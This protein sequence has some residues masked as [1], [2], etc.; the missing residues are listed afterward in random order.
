MPGITG[1][2]VST[3]KRHVLVS[4]F[5]LSS[6]L[7][8]IH[9]RSITISGRAGWLFVAFVHL[10]SLYARRRRRERRHVGDAVKARA[11]C[12]C[13]NS[14]AR[15]PLQNRHFPGFCV[16][17]FGWIV[18]RLRACGHTAGVELS[19]A[20]AVCPSVCY[21]HGPKTV[22]EAGG[23]M[24]TSTRCFTSDSFDRF[25]HKNHLKWH[26]FLEYDATTQW[27]S[28]VFFFFLLLCACSTSLHHTRQP[29]LPSLQCPFKIGRCWLQP[30]RETRPSFPPRTMEGQFTMVSA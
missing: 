28:E 19:I 18:R 3:Y 30:K 29:L 7:H 12:G 15:L 4:G 24:V 23:R 26:I 13:G 27:V 17:S 11:S 16:R 20:V 22:A 8:E 6:D 21:F 2:D 25:L 5:V 10:A 14:S 1:R 9:H